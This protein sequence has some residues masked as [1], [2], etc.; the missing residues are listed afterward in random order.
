MAW[1]SWVS[2]ICRASRKREICLPMAASMRM[3]A[4]SVIPE[5]DIE[6]PE[7]TNAVIAH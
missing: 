6:I 3:P 2:D 7:L 5:D 1:P 4:P